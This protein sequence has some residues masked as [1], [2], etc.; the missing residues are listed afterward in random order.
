[1]MANLKDEAQSWVMQPDGEYERL[2]PHE[3]AFNAQSFFMTN[4]SL[5]GR[6]SALR[7]ERLVR[8]AR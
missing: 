3:D 1:M 5:S 7:K 4:P 6:G 8:R 2:E